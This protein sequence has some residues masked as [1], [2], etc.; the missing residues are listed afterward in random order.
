MYSNDVIMLAYACALK[1]LNTAKSVLL[2]AYKQREL[3][4]KQ[5][6]RVSSPMYLNIL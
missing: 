6:N 2:S 5:V 3:N 1:H 4:N